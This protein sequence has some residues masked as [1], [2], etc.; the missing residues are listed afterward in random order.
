MVRGVGRH[1]ADPAGR[2]EHHR[3]GAQEPVRVQ[4]LQRPFALSARGRIGEV[5]Q[6]LPLYLL[7]VVERLSQ[8]GQGTR[9][10]ARRQPVEALLAKR[11]PRPAQDVGLRTGIGARPDQPA[12]RLG[13]RRRPGTIQRLEQRDPGLSHRT[14][15]PC[16]QL[17]VRQGRGPHPRQQQPAGPVQAYIGAERYTVRIGLRQRQRERLF[18]A[19]QVRAAHLRWQQTRM[20]VAR[21]GQTRQG[22]VEPILLLRRQMPGNFGTKLALQQL[23]DGLLRLQLPDEERPLVGL[24][25]PVDAGLLVIGRRVPDQ[26]RRTPGRRFLSGQGKLD[27]APRHLARRLAGTAGAVIAGGPLG[28]RAAGLAQFR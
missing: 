7:G 17:D 4:L 24:D 23:H 6:P 16:V 15:H 3:Q 11:L 25:P 10:L 20:L 1:R 14:A 18:V 12:Q 22:R 9:A 8:L 13:L 21:L 19:V 2:V 28:A 27:R 5:L 26:R